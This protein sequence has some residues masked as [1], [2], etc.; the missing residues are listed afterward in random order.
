MGSAIEC[1]NGGNILKNSILS[2]NTPT[3]TNIFG[4]F[5][6]A[7]NNISSDKQNALTNSSSLN[8][9]NPMLAPLGNY[10]GPTPTMALLAGSP[11]IDAADSTAFPT[12]DQRGYPR[13]Y[14]K[15]PDIGAFEYSTPNGLVLGAYANGLL[16]LAFTGTNGQTCR[17][18]ASVDLRQWYPIST[19]TLGANGYLEAIFPMTNF[20]GEFYRAVSP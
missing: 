11:A 9:I 18:Q 10:D 3:D 1:V 14:G 20:P 17:I 19:N 12:T 8:G 16:H 13:P 2:P 4:S 15:A 5:I 6:D 7:G